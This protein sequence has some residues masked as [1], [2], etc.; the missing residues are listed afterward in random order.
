[1][2][3]T[4]GQTGRDPGGCASRSTMA[5]DTSRRPANH[6]GVILRRMAGGCAVIV[7]GLRR[8]MMNTTGRE[9]GNRVTGQA[10]CQTF[11]PRGITQQ[12][13][14]VSPCPSGAAGCRHMAGETL[15]LMDISHDAGT[16]MTGITSTGPDKISNVMSGMCCRPIGMAIQATHRSAGHDDIVD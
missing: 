3:F 10:G 15:A 2:D 13:T 1:M 11:Q 14:T 4:V 16:T 9:G 6:G 7:C 8:V 12:R 5:S